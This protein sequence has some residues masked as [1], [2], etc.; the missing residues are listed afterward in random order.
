[1]LGV[2][3][4][5]L[6]DRSAPLAGRPAAPTGVQVD[7]AALRS[8]TLTW[9]HP[10]LTN[11]DFFWVY[12]DGCTPGKRYQQTAGNG[13]TWLDTAPNGGHT[14]YVTAVS[15]VNGYES[16]CSTGVTWP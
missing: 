12:R 11:V 16:D 6:P 1:M 14:Y 5:A 13:T 8:P 15:K 4:V 7:T 3:S 10:D 2:Q 9:T